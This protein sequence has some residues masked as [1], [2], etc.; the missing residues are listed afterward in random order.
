MHANLNF[1]HSGYD[2]AA[3]NYNA[4]LPSPPNLTMSLQCKQIPQSGKHYKQLGQVLH[5]LFLVPK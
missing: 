1:L 4:A 2:M 3:S 5:L